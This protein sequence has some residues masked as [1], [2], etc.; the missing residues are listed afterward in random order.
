MFCIIDNEYY[1]Y[2]NTAQPI[3]ALNFAT[4]II[5]IISPF[6][7]LICTRSVSSELLFTKS[8]IVCNS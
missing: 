2:L 4:V 1:M 6:S 5:I 7:M 8:I 3:T